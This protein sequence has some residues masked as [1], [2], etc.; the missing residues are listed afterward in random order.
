MKTLLFL[1]GWA[2]DSRVWYKQKAYFKDYE[3]ILPELDAENINEI[4]DK[5]HSLCIGKEDLTVIAWSMGWLVALKLLEYQGLN[6]KAMVGISATP[7]FINDDYIE[8]GIGVEE[9]RALRMQLKK[10]FVFALNNFYRQ[11]YIPLSADLFLAKKELFIKQLEIV[12]KED[13]RN[14]LSLIKC[15]AL[16][17]GS[18]NDKICPLAVQ[19]YMRA[20]VDGAVVK[21]MPKAGHAPFLYNFNEVNSLINE[22]ANHTGKIL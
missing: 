5:V 3:I 13:L 10:D 16:F 20:R 12:E 8:Q 14:N 22:Y 9:L 1:H 18:D 15:P 6:I 4:S 2:S 11:N 21:I 17:V 19:E 7:K